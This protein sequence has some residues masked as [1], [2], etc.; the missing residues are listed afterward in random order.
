MY[1]QFEHTHIRACVSFKCLYFTT[2]SLNQIMLSFDFVFFN[3]KHKGLD[4]IITSAVKR[5]SE[6]PV[7]NIK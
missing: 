1:L 7:S 4:L 2:L 6:C 3:A 5:L